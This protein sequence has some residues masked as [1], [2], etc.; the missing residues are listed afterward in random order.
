MKLTRLTKEPI[1]KPIENHP[2]ERSAVFNAGAVYHNGLYHMIYRATDI[3]GSEKY[4]E[5]IN[6]LGYAVS[7][8]LLHW[9]RY[10][11]P[12]LTNDVPQELRGP[13]DP[14]IVKIK[15]TFYMTY[16]GF[17]GRSENDY[18][19]CMA[20][21]TD[22]VHWARKGVL[23][24]E[25]NKDAALFPEKIGGRYCM[26]HRRFPDIWICYSEDMKTWTDHQKVMSP[27]PGTWA[28]SRIGIAG[29]PI[30]IKEG[31][32]LIFHGVDDLHHYRLGALLLDYEDP[33][34]VLALQAEPIIEPEL[35]W[36]INGYI[37]N[38]IFSCATVLKD[39]R[40]Y[41]PYGGADTV[42]GVAYIDLKDVVFENDSWIV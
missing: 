2:W 21:S 26:F 6:S 22:L 37:P 3:G 32:F 30:R 24:D 33:G 41:C 11:K 8:D 40:I 1:L 4:G 39:D 20:T 27:L 31:W 9:H 28:Q 19:I 38:V 25:P 42:I 15:D 5:Y 10:D 29:P 34:R 16:T 13:E 12:I 18:R 23:L 36:E 35:E 14:R 17:G 7:S